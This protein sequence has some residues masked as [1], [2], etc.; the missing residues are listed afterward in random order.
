M[1]GSDT[2]GD[3]P[4]CE[5]AC[6]AMTSTARR[7]PARFP[8]L[9]GLYLAVPLMGLL[10]PQAP[11]LTIG[12]TGAASLGILAL[13]SPGTFLGGA[14]VLTAAV[15]KAGVVVGGLPLPAMMFVLILATVMLRLRTGH[16]KNP[17]YRIA[18]MTMLWLSYRLL[19]LYLDGGSPANVA[20]LAG[21]YGLPVLLLLIGPALG[22]LPNPIGRR[23]ERGLENGILVAC[24][25]SLVQQLLGLER[26]AIPGI[27]RAVGVDYAAKPLAFEGGSKIPSTYQNGNILGVVT[28]V[29]FLVSTDRVL[30]GRGSQRDKLI[31]AATAIA[32]ILSGSRTAVIGLVLGLGLLM[33]RAG[34]RRQTLVTAAL[35][36]FVVGLTLK[37][38]PALSRRLSGTSASDP[39]LTQRTEFWS[40]LLQTTSI[41]EMLIGGSAWAHPL[42]PPGLAE[43][44]IG[45]VQQ[46]GIIGMALFVAVFLT[47]TSPAHLRR[48]RVLLIPV[49]ISMVVDSAYLVFPTLF[50][51][52]AR[53]FAPL[54]PT[55][56]E[57]Q[58]VV[59]QRIATTR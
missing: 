38:S 5:V 46:V 57:Q 37:L 49:A 29:F 32:T 31:M 35:C 3:P 11:L 40:F 7:A 28:A 13:T 19:S 36:T 9:G 34:L 48:W 25:F 6:G 12:A 14:A 39:A 54:D 41:P 1:G 22:S 47:A 27:T 20:A 2:G 4:W 15:P 21:W 24:G 56:S 44:T 52:L 59:P 30:R 45:A 10:L 58:S 55:E 8:T 18:L 50:L 51:P 53:M 42:E 23:W 26:S 43:G 33:L 16:T 17:G